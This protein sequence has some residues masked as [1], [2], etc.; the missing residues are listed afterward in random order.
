MLLPGMSDHLIFPMV[1]ERAT[2]FLAPFQRVVASV[3][4]IHM[5]LELWKPPKGLLTAL[6]VTLESCLVCCRSRST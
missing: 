2:L 6:Y 4:A 5:S 3:D 1:L